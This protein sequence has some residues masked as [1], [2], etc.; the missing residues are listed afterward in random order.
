MKFFKFACAVG[1]S[2][3]FV[4]ASV[5]VAAPAVPH[6]GSAAPAQSLGPDNAGNSPAPGNLGNSKTSPAPGN[7]NGSDA[8]KDPGDPNEPQANR[9][10]DP[11][12]AP[13]PVLAWTTIRPGLELG[14][15]RLPASERM[16]LPDR[17]VVI[18]IHPNRFNFSLQMAS[19]TGE[20]HSFREWAEK[21]DL[22][23]GINASMYLRDNLTSTGMM[24]SATHVNNAKAGSRFGAF[25]AADPADERLPR[26]DILDRDET[27]RMRRLGKYR[28]VVQN[29]RMWNRSG[30]IQWPKNGPAS[31]IAAAGK[32]G[33]GCILFIISQEALSAETFARYVR[34][35]PLG[36]TRLMYLEGGSPTGLVLRMPADAKERA[37]PG[38]SVSV[39]NNHRVYVWRGRS[40]VLQTMG[41]SEVRLPNVLGARPR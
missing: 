36:V 8:R 22:S 17:F 32:D 9:L 33:R 34:K 5:G 24:R 12:T 14:I 16:G 26:V 23:V 25:F 2:S 31:S 7:P 30:V 3:L 20:A 1:V 37:F 10:S 13:L 35:F 6:S 40:S 15:T 29:Y 38:A 27:D 28:L 4:A 11:D 21:G 19:E 18:R 39:V 41:G